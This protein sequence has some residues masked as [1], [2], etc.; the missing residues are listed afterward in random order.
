MSDPTGNNSIVAE[1]LIHGSNPCYFLSVGRPVSSEKEQGCRLSS[2][3][4]SDAL[5]IVLLNSLPSITMDFFTGTSS[6]AIYTAIVMDHGE[7]KNTAEKSTQTVASATT[8]SAAAASS[9]NNDAFLTSFNRCSLLLGFLVG[10]FIQSSSLGANYILTIFCGHDRQVIQDNRTHI[11]LF[12]LGWSFLTSMMGVFILF[13]LR[14]LL[15]VH[16]QNKHNMN[17]SSSSSNNK[18]KEMNALFV[19]LEYSFAFGAL[20]GVCVAWTFTDLLLGLNVHAY[21]SVLTLIFAMIGKVLV[22]YTSCCQDADYDEDE[23]QQVDSNRLAEPLLLD[24]ESG[25]RANKSTLTK[26]QSESMHGEFKFKGICIGLLV[27]FFIQFSSLGASFLLDALYGENHSRVITKKE[28]LSFSLAWSFLFGTMGVMILLLLRELVLMVWQQQQK[29]SATLDWMER[30]C[31][32]LEFYF[33]VGCLLGVNIAWVLTDLGLGFKA[34]IIRS[35][36]T[37]FAAAVWCKVLAHCFAYN[38]RSSSSNSNKSSSLHHDDEEP[39]KP[40]LIV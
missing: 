10:C 17:S 33:A 26:F 31:L 30:L 24:Q 19:H 22:E 8:E 21:H 12:S 5:T 37:L 32:D 15:A 1:M 16:Q 28:L 20:A 3:A 27:G 13:F 11:Y 7:S 39:V 14:N 6:N 35:L 25:S 34:H 2:H 38:L 4:D 23:D 18:T 9:T 40:L 36:L 29:T